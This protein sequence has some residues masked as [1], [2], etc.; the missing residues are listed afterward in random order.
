MVRVESK[1][2]WQKEATSVTRRIPKS[3]IAQKAGLQALPVLR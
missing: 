3:G 2:E 1:C